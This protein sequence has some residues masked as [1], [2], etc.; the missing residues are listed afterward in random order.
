MFDD[1]FENNYSMDTGDAAPANP[2]A[3]NPQPNNIPENNQVNYSQQDNG[4]YSM[5][6]SNERK[7]SYADDYAIN[8]SSINQ[9]QNYNNGWVRNDDFSINTSAARKGYKPQ[10]DYTNNTPP[11]LYN[12]IADYKAHARSDLDW[13]RL[14][15][16][17]L[18]MEVILVLINAV[19]SVPA[20]MLSPN[21][22]A[23]LS[24]I[25]SII[26][27]FVSAGLTA[28]VLTIFLETK[29]KSG[30]TGLFGRFDRMLPMLG[31]MVLMFLMMMA[32]MLIAVIISV[33]A[34]T[35]SN[36]ALAI[37]A[38]VA[39][40]L[41]LVAMVYIALRYALANLICVDGGGVM[42]SLKGS[43]SLMRGR[44]MKYFGLQFSFIGWIL[45]A[46]LFAAIINV[47]IGTTPFFF[48]SEVS[49]VGVV[50]ANL[51]TSAIAFVA[52]IPILVY[53]L[54]SEVEFYEDVRGNGLN[55]IEKTASKSPM[56]WVAVAGLIMSLVSAGTFLLPVAKIPADNAVVNYGTTKFSAGKMHLGFTT[57][58]TP[59]IPGED[60]GDEV[61][62][63]VPDQPTVPDIDE[64][65]SPS[66]YEDPDSGVTPSV[67]ETNGGT[68]DGGDDTFIGI[69][70]TVPS[71]YK[72]SSSS[73]TYV[74][75]YEE[76][77][78]LNSV[79]IN[80]NTADPNEDWSYLT[81]YYNAQKLRVGQFDMYYYTTGENYIRYHYNFIKDGYEYEIAGDNLSDVQSIAE[82]V[83]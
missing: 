66:I 5:D 69:S 13:K 77:T 82:S 52:M 4:G 15:V 67:P 19:F 72:Y 33:V 80:A 76:G 18:V 49:A 26:V 24:G 29:R 78:S 25:G 31:I 61:T 50:L 44:K 81:E 75:Y 16:P 27:M 1:I 73:S 38:F 47:M 14:V 56:I 70:Y 23:V 12:T 40:I 37:V 17:Y 74:D 71:G 48:V 59:S 64:P 28:G 55:P 30:N 54:M 36:S 34:V 39:I 10:M 20:Q 42:D 2:Q 63:T 9:G 65:D 62:P 3:G 11:G 8:T 35:T 68:Q 83:R 45:L 7:T 6:A 53:L 21:I 41:A 57:S 43:A 79:S 46:V 60:G 32:P 22:G 51:N 58:T